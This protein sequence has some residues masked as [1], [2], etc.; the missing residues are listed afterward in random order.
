MKSKHYLEDAIREAHDATAHD[1][2]E[3]RLK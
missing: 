2:V 1:E 3:K